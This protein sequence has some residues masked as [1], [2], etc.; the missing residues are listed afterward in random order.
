MPLAMGMMSWPGDTPFLHKVRK[1]RK[2]DQKWS[3][4]EI[5]L[6]CHT[7]T[8]L[9][10]PRHL[11]ETGGDTNSIPLAIL[12]GECRV[13]EIGSPIIGV[14]EV[15][16]AAPLAGERIIFKTSNS[17]LFHDGNFHES[18]VHINGK[19]AGRLVDAQIVLVGTDG[20]SVDEYGSEKSP[21]HM[22]FC[23]AGIGIIE[24]LL[25]AD[26]EPGEYTL[27]CLPMKLEGADGAPVRAIL[28]K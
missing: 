25:L 5:T 11:F 21:A 9:D 3:N 10:A 16:A 27:I 14:E 26:V 18:F 13:I 8:H 20:P 23:T 1:T 22:A 12:I 28:A 24:N 19:G 6:G 2:G 15:E 4:S 17:A 7:G